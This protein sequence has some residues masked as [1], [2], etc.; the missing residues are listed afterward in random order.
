MYFKQLN[1]LLNIYFN[2][3]IEYNLS[4]DVYFPIKW[5]YDVEPVVCRRKMHHMMI[6]III[7]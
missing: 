4:N 6:I 2:M 3:Q 7:K 5:M 1:Y